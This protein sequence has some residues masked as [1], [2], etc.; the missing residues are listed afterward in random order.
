MD[1]DGSTSK[2]IS[3][4]LSNQGFIFVEAVDDDGWN[5]LDAICLINEI[6]RFIED[7]VEIVV[8]DLCL[9]RDIRVSDL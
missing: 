6:E 7:W 2:V 4:V 9:L 8:D 5:L 3:A 1:P